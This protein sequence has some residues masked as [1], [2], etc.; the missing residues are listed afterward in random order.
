MAYSEAQIS[1]VLAILAANGGN[2]AK[3]ARDTGH[4]WETVKKW[5][6]LRVPGGDIESVST[7]TR[8]KK[9]SLADKFE[10]IA[11]KVLDSVLGDELKDLG[12]FQ[13]RMTG[14]GVAVDKM[15]LLRGQG[16]DAKRGLDEFLDMT[17]FDDVEE[18]RG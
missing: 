3:T 4:S 9:E 1:D 2:I 5:S 8:Q 7:K 6:Q 18:A 17:D 15:R 13:S 12:S 16:D 11:H 14:A 10:E